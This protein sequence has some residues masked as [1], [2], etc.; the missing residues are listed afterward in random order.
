MFAVRLAKSEVEESGRAWMLLV[1][2]GGRALAIALDPWLI[3]M[4]IDERPPLTL[5][6]R[7]HF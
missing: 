1:T 4:R 2:Y 6:L 3:T 7:S 5:R